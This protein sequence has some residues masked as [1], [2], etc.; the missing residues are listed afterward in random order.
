MA[1][2]SEANWVS[3][4]IFAAAIWSMETPTWTLS[5][6]SSHPVSQEAMARSWKSGCVRSGEEVRPATT[7]SLPA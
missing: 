6:V 1:S 5:R 7:T 3:L 4:A 2:S